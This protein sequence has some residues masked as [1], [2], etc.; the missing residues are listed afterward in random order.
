VIGDE[1]RKDKPTGA[2]RRE[3]RGE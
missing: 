3:G 2:W 1:T